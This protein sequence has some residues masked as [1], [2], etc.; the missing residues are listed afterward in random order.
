ML[1]PIIICLLTKLADYVFPLANEVLKQQVDHQ[2]AVLKAR[3]EGRPA[4]EMV[5][6]EINKAAEMLTHWTMIFTNIIMVILF[7]SQV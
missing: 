5:Q 1:K 6:D 3:Q 7:P 4:P 2:K